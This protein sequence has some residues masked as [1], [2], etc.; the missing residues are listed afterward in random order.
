M[1]DTGLKTADILALDRTRLAADRTLMA[2]L[3]T[4]LSMITFGFTI[5]KFL[6]VVR[7][8]SKAPIL[9][10]HSPRNLG[11]TLI[12]IGTFALIA[13]CAQYWAYV[14]RLSPARPYNPWNLSFIVACL[15]TLLGLLL[16]ASIVFS[17][18]PFE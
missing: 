16:F 15:I 14:R 4:S 10:P 1:S 8:Q 17:V 3:R 6:Q 7:E 2:W 5:Y 12:G 13:A 18:G 11:L 9:R